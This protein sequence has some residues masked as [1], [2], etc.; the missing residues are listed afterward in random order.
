MLENLVG[1]GETAQQ[2]Q[3]IGAT[4]SGLLGFMVI[5]TIA[6]IILIFLLV[7]SGSSRDASQDKIANRQLDILADFTAKLDKV[8]EAIQDMS[9]NHTQSNE[10]LSTR[11]S[12][13]T[14]NIQRHLSS[15]TKALDKTL[16]NS[17]TVISVLARVEENGLKLSDE[18]A[19]ALAQLGE[20]RREVK[21]VS[22]HVAQSNSGVHELAEFVRNSLIE[23]HRALNGI[24]ERVADVPQIR[25]QLSDAQ[26]QIKKLADDV[27]RLDVPRTELIESSNKGDAP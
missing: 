8:A 4:T 14:D 19:G 13:Y 27:Q 22:S 9:R 5:I 3:E 17:I 24:A 26:A 23:V 21:E 25:E 6:L 12:E 16:E 1:L 18:L 20:A 15:F 2:L 7:R 11:I 10:L